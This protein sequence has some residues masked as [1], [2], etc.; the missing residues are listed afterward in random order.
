MS[1]IANLQC[2]VGACRGLAPLEMWKMGGGGLFIM[3]ILVAC[4]VMGALCEVVGS[5]AGSFC[6][7]LGFGQMGLKLRFGC[8]GLCRVGLVLECQLGS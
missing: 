5:V 4:R 7:F 1:S 8:L 3:V 6:V 2:L